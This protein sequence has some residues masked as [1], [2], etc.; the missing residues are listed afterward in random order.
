MKNILITGGAGFLGSHLTAKLI[1]NK[2]INV[3]VVDNFITADFYNIEEFVRKPNF[4]FLKYDL[5]QPLNLDKF[6]ELN[7]FKLKIYGIEE[8]YHLACPTSPRDY[9]RLPLQ[10][11]LANSHA[12]KNMLDLAKR[13]KAK[14]LFVSASAVYGKIPLIEQPVSE[15]QWG[16]LETLGP[17]AC[18]SD[19]KRFAEN[20]TVYSGAEFS[21]PTKIVR[22]FHT[23]GPKMRLNDGRI[24]PDLVM[25]AIKGQDIIIYG[26]KNTASTFCYVEDMIDGLVKMMESP[27]SGPINLGGEQLY[28]LIDVAQ[29]I[30]KITESS[31]NIIFKEPLPYRDAEP[32]PDITLAKEKLGWL[33]VTSLEDG[34]VKTVKAMQAGQ[35][36]KF[37]P[38]K[39]AKI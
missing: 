38:K 34:L 12:S 24:V 10:T 32:V 3:I 39:K 5:I 35:I 19:G 15:T 16:T 22:V 28:R 4:E 13:F 29:A 37:K 20:L 7:K 6:D 21:F 31:S 2:D 17:R 23:Y 25:Q 30:S 36:V 14:F 9:D 27:E 1:Q 8:I 33:P 26:D 11:C 18:Y